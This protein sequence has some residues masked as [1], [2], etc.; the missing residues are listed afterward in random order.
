MKAFLKTYWLELAL[1][2][3][4]QRRI[5]AGITDMGTKG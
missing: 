5:M 4:A 3:V 2:A 1:F